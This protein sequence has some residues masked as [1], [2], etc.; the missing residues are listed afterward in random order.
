MKYID[1]SLPISEEIVVWPG[2]KKPV[3]NQYQKMIDRKDS[4]NSELE[5]DLHTGTHFD[6]PLHFISN[7]RVFMDNPIG[8][9]SRFCSPGAYED[10]A[11]NH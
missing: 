5:I 11:I 3:I 7:G 1:I 6:S 4:N 8:Y 10:T 9:I 2:S